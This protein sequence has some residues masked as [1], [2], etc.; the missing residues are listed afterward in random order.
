MTSRSASECLDGGARVD[1]RPEGVR[2]YGS[3]QELP[4]EWVLREILAMTGLSEGAV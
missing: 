3:A 4:V 2:L 1:L